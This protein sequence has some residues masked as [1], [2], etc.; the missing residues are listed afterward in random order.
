MR[1]AHLVLY[2]LDESCVVCSARHVGG[3]R[4]RSVIEEIIS[5]ELNR[6]NLAENVMNKPHCDLIFKILCVQFLS[7]A[8][9][10]R[11]AFLC[12]TG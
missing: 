9:S 4:H 2:L 6:T 3:V 5:R 12:V 7:D 1:K 10:T 8:L 11:E